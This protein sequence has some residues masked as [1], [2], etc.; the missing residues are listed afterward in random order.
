MYL[1]DKDKQNKLHNDKMIKIH[2]DKLISSV[3]DKITK[4][5]LMGL[6][7]QMDINWH[8]INDI[9]KSVN[10]TFSSNIVNTTSTHLDI[11]SSYLN[12]QKKIYTE[13]SHYSSFWL[14]SLM[15]PT[16]IITAGAS[17]I[18]GSPE[19]IPYSQLIISCITA[20]SAFLLSIINFLK[21]DAASEAHKM[22]AHQYD[23]LQSHI[24]FLSGKSLLFS[25]AAFN[26]YTR[27]D[28]LDKIN[29]VAKDKVRKIIQEQQ[30]QNN[31][32]L[33][34]LK[35]KYKEEKKGLIEELNNTDQDK[36]KISIF[37]ARNQY[38]KE[39]NKC[40]DN[41]KQFADKFETLKAAATEKEM[42]KINNQDTDLQHE[43][44]TDILKEIDEVQKKIN[45]I[46]ETNQFEI[47]RK[48]RNTYPKSY[49]INV[50]S[51][52]KMIED[53]RTIL[54]IKLWICRNN[55]R[56]NR[57]WLNTCS[58]IL[59]NNNI[60]LESRNV[61]EKEITNLS[62]AKYNFAEK[63]NTIYESIVGLSVAYIEIDH[64]LSDEAEKAEI[65]R[66]MGI[67]SCFFHCCPK[68]F[69]TPNSTENNFINH[70][71]QSAGKNVKE[72]R[73]IDK[74]KNKNKINI[75]LFNNDDDDIMASMMV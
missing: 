10:E 5:E 65:I 33:Q 55:L 24:M 23:K 47:P 68:I 3:T 48:I 6:L 41:V 61:L 14:N 56:Q 69:H 51:H 9:R 62:K 8:N 67:F 31:I 40:E 36:L 59:L 63:K 27:I 57:I 29:L 70:I 2:N 34:Q 20:F 38:K 72:L 32:K 11:I 30:N 75:N 52:I 22:S 53:Y 45:E 17:V 66:S 37:N 54:T 50:F 49:N 39:Y 13:S 73:G 35:E 25:P 28:R 12:S 74:D 44:I 60:D 15:I 71:Y 4:H 26:N 16:I 46:K 1:F 42:I 7:Q 58:R 18:S 19:T 21:L 64:I 43:L